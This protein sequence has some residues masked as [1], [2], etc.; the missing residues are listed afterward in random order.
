MNIKTNS[1]DL[2]PYTLTAHVLNVIWLV[3]Q[4]PGYNSVLK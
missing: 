4:T 3:C 1:N 2:S